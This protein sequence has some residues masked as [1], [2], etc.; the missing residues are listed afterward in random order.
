MAESEKRYKQLNIRISEE[1]EEI[2]M[3]ESAP[4]KW[5]KTKLANEILMD[6]AKKRK[7]NG[8]AIQF[9]NNNIENINIY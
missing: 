4:L 7:Q 6:W 8:G 2:L 9:I 5:T 3:Q 1:L